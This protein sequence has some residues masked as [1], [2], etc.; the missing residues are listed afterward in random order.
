MNDMNEEKISP[1][2]LDFSEIRGGQINESWL[3]QMGAW[4]KW[5]LNG[6]FGG[7]RRPQLRVKGSQRELDSFARTLSGEANYMKAFKKYGLDDTQ[8]LSS[9]HKLEDAIKNFERETGIKWP[10]K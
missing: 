8:T 5:F 2:V 3:G 4:V 6:M 1:Q 10:L 7:Y 9:R